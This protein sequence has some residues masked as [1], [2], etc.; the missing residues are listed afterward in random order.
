MRRGW[1]AT[2]TRIDFSMAHSVQYNSQPFVD[3]G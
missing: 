2:R 3:R 1:F